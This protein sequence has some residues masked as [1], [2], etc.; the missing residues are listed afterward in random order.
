MAKQQQNRK[1]IPI[2]AIVLIIVVIIAGIVIWRV[3]TGGNE[4]T[5]STNKYASRAKDADDIKIK[6]NDSDE[7]KVEKLQGKIELLNKEIDEK[8][9]E[10]DKEYEEINK[11]YEEY[12]SVMNEYQEGST[13]TT[14]VLEEGTEFVQEMPEEENAESEEITEE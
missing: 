2:I 13:D 3:A 4:N 12:V 6:D 8:Q 14:V 11:L 5:E 9:A 1:N 10:L 7:V